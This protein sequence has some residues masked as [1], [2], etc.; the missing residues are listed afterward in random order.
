MNYF[1]PAIAAAAIT[2]ALASAPFA[3]AG[4]AVGLDPTGNRAYGNYADLWTNHTDTAL[5]TGFKSITPD[6]T[7]ARQPFVPYLTEMRTQMVIGTM[8]NGAVLNTPSGLNSGFELSAVVRFQELVDRQTSS[9]PG[10]SSAHFS[11]PTSQAAA[12]DV[13]AQHGGVQNI[14]FYLDHF[15]SGAAT[16][17]AAGGNGAGYVR[18][19]GSGSTSA[20]CGGAG[21]TDNDG[22]L[23]MSGHLIAL[24]ANATA[25]GN[26]STGAFELSYQIDY[27]D[28]LY[29]DIAAGAV[30]RS[31][32]TGAATIPSQQTPATMWDGTLPG[33]VPLMKF[34][35]SSSFALAAVPEP[36]TLALLGLGF[37]G[38]ALGRRRQL[39]S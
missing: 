23:I 16:S 29:L 1:K 11:L 34:D 22:V 28:P 4:P 5:A 17:Q 13:D 14:A 37:V 12:M 38:M 2:T 7:S 32:V 21:D 35:G 3:H 8:S 33:S 15:V 10:S 19:Y 25:A 30:F 6:A 24:E 18:C 27:V 20:G 26:L 31:N 9:A 39:P 36:A